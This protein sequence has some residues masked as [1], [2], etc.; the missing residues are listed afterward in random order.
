MK[1]CTLRSFELCV[2][3]IRLLVNNE[4]GKK[5]FSLMLDGPEGEIIGTDKDLIGILADI[6]EACYSL[7]YDDCVKRFVEEEDEDE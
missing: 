7:E 3:G 5:T 1:D 4:T 6:K 2:G